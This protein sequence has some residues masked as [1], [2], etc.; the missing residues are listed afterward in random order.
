M[1][2]SVATCPIRQ[3]IDNRLNRDL[4]AQAR[5]QGFVFSDPFADA[6]MWRGLEAA[7][8]ENPAHQCDPDEADWLFGKAIEATLF[9]LYQQTRRVGGQCSQL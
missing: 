2:Y 3:G 5:E 7:D 9:F 4:I 6:D 8:I 1:M